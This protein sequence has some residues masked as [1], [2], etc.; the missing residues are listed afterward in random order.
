V[1]HGLTLVFRSPGRSRVKLLPL[2]LF[3]TAAPPYASAQSFVCD[4]VRRGDTA[5]RLAVRLT[6]DSANRH[7]PWFQILDPATSRFV[8]KAAYDV[9]LPGWRVCIAQEMISG[10][11]RPQNNVA[12]IRVTTPSLLD[13]AAAMLTYWWVWA[14]GVAALVPALSVTRRYLDEQ[15]AMRNSMTRFA[16]SFVREF[17]RPLP[18]RHSADRPIA[19]RLRCA[20]YR[21]RLD[22]QL[23]PNRGHTYPNLRDH[24]NNLDYD[25]RRVLQLLSQQPFVLGEPYARGEWVVI[26]FQV[27]DRG[28]KEGVR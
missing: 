1:V 5:A 24:K 2:L 4:T 27:M 10:P 21:A 18:R 13:R 9:I 6:N 12:P 25:I 11:S 8:S 7:Q 3:L 22:I 20:P 23:A 16:A 19:A 14:I 26:P 28:A 17:E 15:R